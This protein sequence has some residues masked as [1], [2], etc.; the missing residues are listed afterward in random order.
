MVDRAL[1][2]LVKLALEPEW[3]AGAPAGPEPNSYGFRPARCC[4]D[5]IEAIYNY[6][7]LNPKFVLATKGR[8]RYREMLRCKLSQQRHLAERLPAA[9]R[10]EVIHKHR[11]SNQTA[12]LT[13]LN[14]KVRG[15]TNYYRACTAKKVFE[16]MDSQMHWKL[17]RW[18]KRRHPH[19]QYDYV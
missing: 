2:A 18:A 13:E 3:E 1:Q 10:R 12:L 9:G 15:W 11:G 16:R 8:P 19:K 5:A 4:Q 17:L 7:R 14:P 6:I